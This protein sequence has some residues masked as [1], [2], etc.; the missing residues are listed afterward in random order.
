[1]S[2]CKDN[3][4]ATLLDVEYLV[5]APGGGGVTRNASIE[6]SAGCVASIGP[7]ITNAGKGLL[8]M[9]A[10]VDAHD[11]ARGLHHLALAPAT[12]VSRFGA[13]RFMLSRRL[14]SI[15]IARWHLAA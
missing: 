11:H 8:A 3:T 9:P 4:D 1:M 6:F 5:S 7:G 10:L 15:A 2:N 13:Q 12:K 14:T